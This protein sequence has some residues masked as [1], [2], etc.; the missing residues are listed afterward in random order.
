MTFPDLILLDIMMPGMSGYEVCKQLKVHDETRDIPVI[1]MSALY[2]VPDKVKAFAVGGVDYITKP[3]Q[4]AEILARIHTHI[5]LRKLQKTLQLQ[6]DQ[7]QQEILVRE[8]AESAMRLR[9]WELELLTQMN[10][11]LQTCRGEPDT[12]TVMKDMCQQLFPSSSGGV[13]LIA[14]S[15]SSLD[16]A[17]TWGKVP[18]PKVQLCD[19]PLLNR[20][21]GHIYTFEQV[22]QAPLHLACHAVEADEW[23]PYALRNASG[24]MLGVLLL[25]FARPESRRSDDDDVRRMAES[26]LLLARRVAEQYALFLMNLRLREELKREAIRD[27]LT[28]LFNR[29]Y[30]EEALIREFQRAERHKTSVGIIMLDIDHFK[31]FNDRFGHDIGDLIL[32]QLGLLLQNSI[33]GGD[34]ACRYGGEEFLLILPDTTLETTTL[35]AQELLKRARGIQ[36]LGQHG[37]HHITISLGVSVFPV[38]GHNIQHVVNAAD[39]ALYQAKNHGRNRVEIA[40]L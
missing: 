14:E 6:N 40:S 39:M 38:H 19:T 11:A 9:N 18:F 26:R 34:V 27:P 15:R 12:Y 25:S 21:H 10:T 30:M 33:R 22:R 35:R 29:R 13:A 4:A 8:R 16:V 36:F 3:F 31:Q 2:D 37:M 23:E 7:L 17:V 24:Q 1:F 28:D 32:E 20:F 5:T